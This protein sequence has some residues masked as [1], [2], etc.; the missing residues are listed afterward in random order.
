MSA[1][2]FFTRAIQVYLDSHPS[3][4]NLYSMATRYTYYLIAGNDNIFKSDLTSNQLKQLELVEGLATYH[5]EDG[6]TH[7]LEAIQLAYEHIREQDLVQLHIWS[8]AVEVIEELEEVEIAE[9]KK[10]TLN[11]LSLELFPEYTVP[12]RLILEMF[13]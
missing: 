11:S 5:M 12:T 13:K 1:R 8:K 7:P 4:V 9:I 3:K 2:L 10:Y 6:H